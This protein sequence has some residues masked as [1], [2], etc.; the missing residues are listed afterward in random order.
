MKRYLKCNCKRD[1]ELELESI[2]MLLKGNKGSG[3]T[4]H[5]FFFFLGTLHRGKIK[6]AT[7]GH[8]RN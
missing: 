4:P 6:Y 1:S 8:V 3:T 7:Q 2:L 5:F